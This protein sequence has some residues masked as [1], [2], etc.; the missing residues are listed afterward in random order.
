MTDDLKCDFC[1]EP[2]CWSYPARDIVVF[3]LP[4][5]QA[6]K[7]AWA[8]CDECSQLIDAEDREGLARRSLSRLQPIMRVESRELLETLRTIHV[9]FWEARLGQRRPLN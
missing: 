9:A 2:A 7:G 6:S 4:V 1:S 5:R 3:E 8:A